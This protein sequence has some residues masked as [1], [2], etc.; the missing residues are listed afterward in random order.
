VPETRQVSP[1]PPRPPHHSDHP[2]VPSMM[3]AR[4]D[5]VQRPC[6]PRPRFWR[7]QI[8]ERDPNDGR[9]T[10]AQA[11]LTPSHPNGVPRRRVDVVVGEMG[12][13][14]LPATW[15]TLCGNPDRRP[16]AAEPYRQPARMV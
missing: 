10:Y 14:S 16:R 12:S 6:R 8:Q 15:P 1:V 2:T 11:T 5:R 3:R 4:D 13:P 7:Y 9:P